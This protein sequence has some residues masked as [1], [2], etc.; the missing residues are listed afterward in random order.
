MTLKVTSDE[1]QIL[2][3]K[4]ELKFSNK[5]PL[6]FVAGYEM[7]TVEHIVKSV[8]LDF[9]GTPYTYDAYSANETFNLSTPIKSNEIPVIYI[10]LTNVTGYGNPAQSLLNVRQPANAVIPIYVRGYPQ[11]NT[12]ASDTTQLAISPVYSNTDDN[13]IVDYSSFIRYYPYSNG[14]YV[15]APGTQTD[16]GMSGATLTYTWEIYKYRYLED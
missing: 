1:I 11:D 4:G 2:N 8:T 3:S 13:Y 9:Y 12:P 16:Q 7:G 10:T 15:G 6:M 14:N 5:Q